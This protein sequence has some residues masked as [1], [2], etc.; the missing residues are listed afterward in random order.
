MVHVSKFKLFH[1]VVCYL[2]YPQ[3]L[4]V[5]FKQSH[6]HVSILIIYVQAMYLANAQKLQMIHVH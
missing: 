6:R 1:A 3:D 2:I 4:L 5:T